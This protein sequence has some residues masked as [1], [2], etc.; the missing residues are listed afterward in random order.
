MSSWSRAE[1]LKEE[2]RVLPSVWPDFSSFQ[3]E[4]VICLF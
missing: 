1:Y 4:L 3:P 2:E